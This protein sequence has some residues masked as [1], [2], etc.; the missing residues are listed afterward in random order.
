M[1]TWVH[2]TSTL[3]LRA[4]F[5]SDWFLHV[6]FFLVLYITPN[7]IPFVHCVRTTI[8]IHTVI[9]CGEH[10][11]EGLRFRAEET[12]ASIQNALTSKRTQTI[13]QK[14]ALVPALEH[15]VQSVLSSCCSKTFT[16]TNLCGDCCVNCQTLPQQCKYRQTQ[17]PD[18]H[19]T[20]F[21]W[22]HLFIHGGVTLLL[23]CTRHSFSL[24]S[25]NPHTSFLSCQHLLS[26]YY[27]TCNNYY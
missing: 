5:A 11:F 25:I 1:V 10:S 16:L 3:R 8:L 22:C 24:P 12:S 27:F 26:I 2:A 19:G 7:S 13:Y 4:Q 15:A 20:L 23:H 6:S 17:V 18:G 9:L 21:A 14:V